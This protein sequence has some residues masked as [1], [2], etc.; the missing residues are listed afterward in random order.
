M[1][2][3]TH[4]PSVSLRST[5]GLRMSDDRDRGAV[6]PWLLALFVAIAGLIG[7]DLLEDSR[8]G[9][10]LAHLVVELVVVS[11]ALLGAGLLWREARAARREARR[12]DA[13]LAT[14]RADA[15]RWRSEAQEVLRGLGAA[16]DVQF[17]RWGLTPAEREVGLLLLKGLSH[18]EAAQVR[19]ASERT[20]RQQALALYRKAGLGGRSE[21]AA[22]FLED[23]LLP[24]QRP[25]RG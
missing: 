14:A 23:L 16:I 15:Q 2:Q 9:T 22:F 10:P 17:E 25:D 7:A 11:L 1:R 3:V 18:K 5:W 4:A 20:V 13:D 24:G 21:L 6:G 19:G 8:A 12:L